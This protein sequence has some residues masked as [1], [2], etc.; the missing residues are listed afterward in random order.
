L[1][2]NLNIDT[3]IRFTQNHVGLTENRLDDILDFFEHSQVL[4]KKNIEGDTV[5][6]AI[7]EPTE[8]QLMGLK[9]YIA[10]LLIKSRFIVRS[11]HL[12]KRALSTIRPWTKFIQG[13]HSDTAILLES[14]PELSNIISQTSKPNFLFGAGSVN[15]ISIHWRLGDYLSNPIH[16]H[17]HGVISA[18]Q[19]ISCV[20]SLPVE[21]RDYPIFLYSDSIEIAKSIFASAD[22]FQRM[23]FLCGDIWQDLYAMTRSKIFIGSHSSISVWVSLSILNSNNNATVYLPA[24]WFKN[25]PSGFI[26][27][28]NPFELPHVTLPQIRKY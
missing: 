12:S 27:P 19:I 13:Y 20:Q 2:K 17:T 8:S 11:D 24:N 25:I 22:F 18:E 16:N 14:I 1:K 7:R 10:S 21:M 28:K 4:S 6:I 3:T 23:T 9:Q 5:N 26:D 15:S